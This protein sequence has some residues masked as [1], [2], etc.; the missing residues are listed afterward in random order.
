MIRSASKRD[1]TTIIKLLD[2][3]DLVTSDVRGENI[4]FYIYEIE[5]TVVAC[6]GLE[7]FGEN[8][9]LRSLCTDKN[10]RGRGIGGELVEALFLKAKEKSITNLYLLTETAE[11]FFQKKGFNPILKENANPDILESRQ[12]A[13]LCPDSAVCMK[14]KLV[15]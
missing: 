5:A 13:D 6:I 8:G 10:Y 11:V 9:L 4:L 1:F 3:N 14:K 2:S 12:F 7:V 15:K